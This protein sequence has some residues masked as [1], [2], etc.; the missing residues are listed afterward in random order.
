[1]ARVSTRASG[2]VLG[3]KADQKSRL[4]LIENDLTF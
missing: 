3:C 1:M 2:G 4:V